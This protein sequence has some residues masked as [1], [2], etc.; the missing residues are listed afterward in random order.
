MAGILSWTTLT[1]RINTLPDHKSSKLHWNTFKNA[2]VLGKWKEKSVNNLRIDTRPTVY[3]L[4]INNIHCSEQVY[5]G[6][7][8]T[9]Y[10]YARCTLYVY[11]KI[12]WM[13]GLSDGSVFFIIIIVRSLSFDHIKS[14]TWT[15][16]QFQLHRTDIGY[17]NRNIEIWTEP[18]IQKHENLERNYVIYSL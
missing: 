14:I 4:V 17:R 16:H 1:A 9:H 10:I 2:F 8:G 18:K 13:S 3:F 15:R 6:G 5:A 12:I 7:L 11:S